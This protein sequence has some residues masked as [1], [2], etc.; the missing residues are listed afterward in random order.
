MTTWRKQ[1]QFMHSPIS[2]CKKTFPFHGAFALSFISSRRPCWLRIWIWVICRPFELREYIAFANSR[3]R[4]KNVLLPCPIN[5]MTYERPWARGQRRIKPNWFAPT[6]TSSMPKR[7]KT[8]LDYPGIE[9]K[10]LIE[11]TLPIS[12]WKSIV[13]RFKIKS[14]CLQESQISQ[15]RQ[16]RIHPQYVANCMKGEG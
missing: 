10:L 1:E 14:Y 9:S 2:S 5:P 8:R 7:C 15:T 3:I 4:Q 13:S 16:S 6:R 12:L 11:V